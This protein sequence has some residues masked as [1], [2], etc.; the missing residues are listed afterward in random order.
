MKKIYVVTIATDVKGYLNVLKESCDIN[1]FKFIHL[2]YKEKWGGFIWKFYKFNCFLNSSNFNDDDII[3]FVDGYDTI[4][5]NNSE[6][7]LKKFLEYDTNILISQNEDVNF[8][9]NYINKNVFK[10]CKGL[11]LNT[12]MYMGYYKYLKEL[13]NILNDF[14]NFEDT[15][16]DDQIELTRLCN[17]SNPFYNN[18]VKIDIHNKIFLNITSIT[19]NFDIYINNVIIV[20]NNKIY[21]KNGCDFVFIS[22]PNNTSLVGV[23]DL[24]NFKSYYSQRSFYNYL[25]KSLKHFTKYLLTEL[26]ILIFF[27]IL[28]IFLFCKYILKI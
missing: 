18:N 25:F 8:L 15:S 20:E 2:G 16:L 12:G 5:I 23:I 28:T 10:D 6:I 21:L 7:L 9:T 27:I 1:G 14:T 3:V 13:M 24:Y 11:Y 17:S 4:C 26:L 22:G 19:G